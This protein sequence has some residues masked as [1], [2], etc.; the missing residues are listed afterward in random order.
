[1]TLSVFYLAL[2][3]Y[4]GLLLARR[5]VPDA[6]AGVLLPLG[7]GF[8]VSLLAALPAVFALPL[9]F[10][11]PAVLLA[12]AAAA[13]IGGA[14]LRRGTRLR[15]VP[16]GTDDGALWVCLLPV[17]LLTLY[18]LH[19]HVLHMVNG[20]YH[21][22]QSC[23]GD[24]PMHLGFIQYIA[25]SGEFLPRYPLLGGD[26]R[27]GYPFL[28]ETVSSVFLVL[29]ADLRTAYLLPELPAFLAVYGMLW[30][31]A[32]RVTGSAAK[33]SLAF[34]LFFMGSGFGFVYFLGS[35][36]SFAGIFTGFYT[37]PTNFVEE[38]IEWVNPIVDLLIPQRATLFGWCVLLPAMYLLW[39]FCYE[40][41][42]RLWPWLAALVLPLPLLQTHSALALV[43]L[44]LVGGVY[45]L[46]QD[47]R[48]ETLLPW[49]G[50][51]AVCGAVWLAQMLPTVLAQSLDGQH[52]LR[53]HFNWS[54][55]QDDG[56]LKDNYFWFYIKNIGLVYLLLIPAFIHASRRQR[57]LYGG[58]LVILALAELVEFQPNNYDNNKLLFIWHMLGCILVAQLLAD[59]FVRVRSLPWRTLGLAA[60]CLLAMFGSVLTVGREIFSDYQQWSADDIALADYVDENAEHDA[61]FLTSDSHLTPV[62]ALAGRRILC[63]S[64]SYIYYHGMDYADE[65]NAMCSLY[66]AP[67]EA[68]L[69]AWD[70]GYVL[71]DSSVYGKFSGADES[72][73]AERYPLWYENN[74]CRV[75]KIA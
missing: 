25:Q 69:A 63:G 19:T 6:D 73:Y 71:F 30:Q 59:V 39:R 50:L 75:Y 67:D 9:G 32:R 72:W 51:A 18:L 43:L 37:T 21:T 13:G 68:T 65:Y 4:V 44:C 31:L 14:L 10:T 33:A 56:T 12:A 5:A 40:G 17:A 62:F 7:C 11:L 28:C 38:N 15:G 42:R 66:E 45:T 46:A 20:A 53:L 29:G 55:G 60:C 16:K 52:M 49:L 1:M 27:F 48:R 36:E 35:A 47:A 61:L 64:S 74:G 2:F 8:G 34:Y 22:G 41:E 24:T 54:N 26:H 23:Y 70:I 57:W 58:G 3:L